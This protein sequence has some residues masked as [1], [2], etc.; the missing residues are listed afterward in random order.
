MIDI[1][2]LLDSPI[3]AR[4]TRA[5]T[6]SI[7]AE[8]GYSLRKYA[9]GELIVEEGTRIESA[10]FVYS[11]RV[12]TYFATISGRIVNVN[13]L[14]TPSAIAQDTLFAEGATF[15]VSAE[16]IDEVVILEM[17]VKELLKVFQ[18]SPIFLTN[19][20]AYVSSRFSMM[21]NRMRMMLMKTIPQKL[22]FLILDLAGKELDVVLLP[23]SQTE[24][25]EYLAVTRP[26]LARGLRQLSEMK[27]ISYKTRKIKILDKAGLVKLLEVKEEA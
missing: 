12:Q 20:L 7:L 14:E 9:P 1:E 24:L 19:Y 18:H 13:V 5:E 22:A 10:H 15:P 2:Y 6:Q 11:G 17:P 8:V 16:A 23:M 21:T 26:S 25:A 3:F 27:L 4:M